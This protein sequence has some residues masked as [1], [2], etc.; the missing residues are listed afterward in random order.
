MFQS[1]WICVLVLIES[2][3]E[4]VGASDTCIGPIGNSSWSCGAIA[5]FLGKVRVPGQILPNTFQ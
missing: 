3:E 2:Q 1:N 5:G 4:Q